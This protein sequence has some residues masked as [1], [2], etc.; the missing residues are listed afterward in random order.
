MSVTTIPY[1]TVN[2]QSA[3]IT[4]MLI[5]RLRRVGRKNDPSFRVIVTD[6]RRA[7][8]AGKAVEVLGAYD[9]RRGA[10]QINADRVKHWLSQ[11]AQV[12]GTVHNLLVDQKIITGKKINKI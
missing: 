1:L 2:K 5:I 4:N 7:A 3:N 10:P 9:A 11:G 8:K 6:H 12:S